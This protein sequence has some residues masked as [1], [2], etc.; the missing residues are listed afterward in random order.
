MY[1]HNRSLGKVSSIHLNG[2]KAYY[3]GNHS[4]AET[5]LEQA[6]QLQYQHYIP[7]NLLT[8]ETLVLSTVVAYCQGKQE[9]AMNYLQ[10]AMEVLRNQYTQHPL[11]GKTFYVAGF[12]YNSLRNYDS[13]ILYFKEALSV[14][15][16]VYPS[17]HPMITEVHNII[18]NGEIKN[19]LCREP[20]N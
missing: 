4:T 16:Q 5:L 14:V 19:H 17:S 15:E 10:R 2:W 6:L 9:E 13:A 11:V 1:H 18:S 12:L 20:E 8:A 7:N 3:Q